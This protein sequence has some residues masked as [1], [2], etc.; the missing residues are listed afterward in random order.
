VEAPIPP[1]EERRL[2]ALHRLQLA[3]RESDPDLEALTR[4]AA[5]V[6]GCRVAAVSAIEADD[7]V[8]LAA[9]GRPP[10]TIPRR[11][12]LCAHVVAENATIHVADARRDRR[13]A[14]LPAVALDPAAVR[15]YASVPLRSPD[16]LP[17]GTLCACDP[18]PALLDTIQVAMLEDLAAQATHLLDLERSVRD[19]ATS[20]AVAD[21]LASHDPLT[22]VC[23]ARHFYEEV[24]SCRRGRGRDAPLVVYCDLDGFK[25]V[26]DTHGHGVGDEVLVEVA[27]RISGVLRHDDVVARLGGDEFAVLC[28]DLR[29]DD[30]VVLVERLRRAVEAPIPTSAGPI[31]V[32]VSVGAARDDGGDVR[33]AVSAADAAMYRNKNVRRAHRSSVTGT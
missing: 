6:C 4:V 11:E 31:T 12:S 24:A 22:R 16:G 8:Q 15:R 26:N 10:R 21:H 7:Q 19:L 3:E 9:T 2:A 14:D 28:I 30:V 27:H 17:I 32:G 1:Y 33:T 23:N 18:R 29:E 25:A 20:L 13:F 5:F